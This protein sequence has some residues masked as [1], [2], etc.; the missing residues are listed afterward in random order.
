MN[1]KVQI[2]EKDGRPEY[3]VVPID[4]YRRMLALTEDLEDIRDFDEALRELEEGKDELIP[5]EVVQRLLSGEEH[6]LR[7]WREY[8]GMTQEA[9][10]ELAGVGKS[11]LS[12][13][14]SGKKMGSAR[15]LSALAAALR[16][17]VDDLIATD[18]GA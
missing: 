9:L 7:I 1:A 14:E 15:V 12:Q 5:A 2:I 18:A 17:D 4:L 16:V 6:P 8:R 13:I 11:Y 10:A 3:A